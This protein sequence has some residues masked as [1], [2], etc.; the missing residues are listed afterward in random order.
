MAERRVHMKFR[1]I[2]NENTRVNNENIKLSI[3]LPPI[4]THLTTS[5]GL[6]ITLPALKAS[7][8]W[9]ICSISEL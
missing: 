3:L 4:P 5:L 7:N 1:R 2:D 8:N 6:S 9:N